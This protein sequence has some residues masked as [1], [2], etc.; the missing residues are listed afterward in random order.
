MKTI[1]AWQATSTQNNLAPMHLIARDFLKM[2]AAAILLGLAIGI[3]AAGLAL[4]IAIGTEADDPM[5]DVGTINTN[6]N[7]RPGG[8]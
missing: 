6:T 8:D 7:Y 4:L 3:V 2:L 1:R 5:P